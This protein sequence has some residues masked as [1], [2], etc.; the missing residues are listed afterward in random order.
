MEV[1]RMC[2]QGLAR[3]A[4]GKQ[5]AREGK[6]MDEGKDKG[7][8]LLRATQKAKDKGNDNDNAKG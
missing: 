2:E 4:R 1:H 8:G 3:G 5:G 7:M 6:G